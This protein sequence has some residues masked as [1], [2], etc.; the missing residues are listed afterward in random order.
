MST[1]RTQLFITSDW[2]LGGS[3]DERLGD[4]TSLGSSI[5]RSVSQLTRFLDSLQGEVHAFDGD[6]QIVLNG[7]IVDFLAPNPANNYTPLAWQNNE[8]AICEELTDIAAR[9]VGDD[10]RGP[11]A[12]LSDLASM[13]CQI[14]VLLGNH[15]V[16]LCLPKVR[17]RFVELLGGGSKL[18]FIYDGEAYSCGRLLVEHGNQYDRFNAVD[19]DMLRRER[20]QLSRGMKINDA[21]RG[22]LFFQPPV[23]SSIVVDEVNPRLPNVPFL[24][25]LKPEFSAAIPLMLALYPETR[26]FFELAFEMGKIAKRSY[27]NTPSKRPGL[28]SGR[29]SETHLDL[30]SFL[31]EELATDAE[32]FLGA[33]KRPGQLSGSKT[34]KSSVMSR[35]AAKA[36]ATID[37]TCPWGLY[38]KLRSDDAAE[39]LKSVRIAL[40]RV[41][42]IADFATDTETNVYLIPAAELIKR[43]FEA[44]VFG[45]THFPKEIEMGGG[46]YLNAGTWADVLRLPKEIGS[47]NETIADEA[48]EKF[49]L[50]MK[51]QNYEPYVVRHLSYVRA[52]VERDGSVN[53][54]LKFYSG[55]PPQ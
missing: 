27:A 6:S 1:R 19:F 10:G 44:I 13:G 24:N 47:S 14:V 53:T 28:M 49:L 50:D 11:F 5:F 38:S 42:D 45:H 32:T 20:S 55:E 18:R 33:P 40:K 43:G 48:I 51:Q 30:N 7:D 41:H 2:H 35:L 54:A 39:R 15:D 16:E 25:L 46:K 12:A 31:R 23:G 4:R 21:D 36:A 22:K 52:I 26:K 3:L 9:F 34:D 17:D 29:V 8:A 37:L